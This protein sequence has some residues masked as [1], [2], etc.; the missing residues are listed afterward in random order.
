MGSTA[1]VS[2]RRPR[3]GAASPGL[4]PR[5][6]A[7]RALARVGGKPGQRAFVMAHAQLAQADRAARR[8]RRSDQRHARRLVLR[9]ADAATHAAAKR[10]QGVEV[11]LRCRGRVPVG[12][13][14]NV[15]LAAAHPSEEQQ[16]ERLLCARVAGE[17]RLLRLS[18]PAGVVVAA[19]GVLALQRQLACNR[20]MIRSRQTERRDGE[21]GGLGGVLRIKPVIRGHLQHGAGVPHG[22]G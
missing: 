2:S 12:A 16:A 18:K 10:G 1:R 4:K 11:A 5:R 6:W 19:E 17:R 14:P 22:C 9:G 13:V 8:R 3:A 20:G 21:R 7:H 15:H